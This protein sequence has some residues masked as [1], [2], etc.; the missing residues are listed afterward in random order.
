MIRLQQDY[1]VVG[2]AITQWARSTR[3]HRRTAQDSRTISAVFLVLSSWTLWLL[4]VSLFLNKCKN[5]IQIK[6][7]SLL[8][9]KVCTMR[10]Y[11]KRPSAHTQWEEK[12]MKYSNFSKKAVISGFCRQTKDTAAWPMP[13]LR[14][15]AITFSS[16]FR[17]RANHVV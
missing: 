4:S 12:L 8:D 6:L 14:L 7:N 10:M 17:T 15:I 11:L 5:S 3:H 16:Q 2:I 9:Y 13:I 1:T